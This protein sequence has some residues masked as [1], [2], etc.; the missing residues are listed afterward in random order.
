MASAE[1]KETASPMARMVAEMDRTLRVQRGWTQEQE[2]KE[3]GYSAAAI[4][5]METCAQP[6]SDAMLVELNPVL[7]NGTPIFET[8][9]KYMRMERLPE[10][11]KDYALLEEAALSLQL[12]ATN[13]VHGLFQTEAYARALIGGGYPPLAD[14]RVKELVQL[15]MAR[16]ALF[17]RDPLPMIE[18]ILDEAVLRRVIGNDEIMREQL[19]H[20]VE[21]A[22]RRNVTLLV[23]PLDAG[24]D[25]EYAGAHGE[26]NLLE[27]PEH[28]RLVYLDPQDES[29]L[30]SDPTKV[31]TYTQRYAKIRSQALGPRESL[32]LIKRLAGVKE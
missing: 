2:G 15:R 10:Q 20:L 31:S 19:L 27:T 16:K 29:L 30:I 23:L 17:D 9:R 21:C 8:A 14:E 1:N 25:G 7:G 32:D 13:V 28:E 18:V 26:M 4:S 5:A 6:A 11:F 3:I 12:F 24:K 22:R